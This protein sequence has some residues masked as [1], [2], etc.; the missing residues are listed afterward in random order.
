MTKWGRPYVRARV[1]LYILVKRRFLV[2]NEVFSLFSPKKRENI[3]M[4]FF[5]IESVLL[6]RMDEMT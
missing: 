2:Q 1:P 4:A 6:D 3:R 5:P